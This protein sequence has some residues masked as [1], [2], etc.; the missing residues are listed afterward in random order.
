VAVTVEAM[1]TDAAKA[2]ILRASA[3]D[4]IHTHVFDI[5]QRLPWPDQ[6]PGRALQNA[7]TARWHGREDALRA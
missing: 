3:A 6:F 7:F 2:A 1:G 4:T 5:V